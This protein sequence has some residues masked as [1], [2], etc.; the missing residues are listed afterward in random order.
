MFEIGFSEVIIVIVVACYVFEIK[1]LPKIIKLVKAFYRH[2]N[3]YVEQAKS[4]VS[5][6]EKETIVDL[7]G[8]EQTTYNIEDIMPDIK[9][10][11][12]NKD[13]TK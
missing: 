6:L 10:S 5:E 4:F 13:E 9:P 7:E 11:K 3:H 1:D 8:K 2:V 12:K